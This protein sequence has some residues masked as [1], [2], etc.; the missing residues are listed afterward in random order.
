MPRCF[1]DAR[2]GLNDHLDSAACFFTI[3]LTE[4]RPRFLTQHMDKP[5]A[6]FA[7]T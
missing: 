2:N 6:C 1:E 3:K 5:P 7:R 4:R